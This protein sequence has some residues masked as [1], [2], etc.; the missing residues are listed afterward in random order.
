MTLLLQGLPWLKRFRETNLAIGGSH[1]IYIVDVPATALARSGAPKWV[2][3]G[4]DTIRNMYGGI[5]KWNKYARFRKAGEIIE[6]LRSARLVMTSRLL[7]ALPS[8]SMGIPT[9]FVKHSSMPEKDASLMKL[10]HVVDT[11]AEGLRRPKLGDFNFLHP[12]QNPG[13]D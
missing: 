3:H 10:F 7:I 4:A 13:A 6:S 11:S 5:D 8:V 12:P 9:I 2:L 1:R